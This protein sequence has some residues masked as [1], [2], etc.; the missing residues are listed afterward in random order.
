MFSDAEFS[1]SKVKLKS[2][3]SLLLFT[4]G[5]T[6]TV[7]AE[8]AEFGN[9]RLCESINGFASGGPRELIAHCLQHIENFRGSAERTDDLSMLA[10]SFV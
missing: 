9:R 10:L 3:D 1:S 4:D 7:N 2:G 8:G 6:E 5:V